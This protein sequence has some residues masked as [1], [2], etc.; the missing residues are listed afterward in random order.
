[1][2]LSTVAASTFGFFNNSTTST[3]QFNLGGT[4]DGQAASGVEVLTFGGTSGG[5]V[6][7]A[8]G[9]GSG[10][11]TVALSKNGRGTWTL[12]GTNTYTGGTSIAGGTLLLD[13]N[14]GGS[15]ATTG[16]LSLGGGVFQIKGASGGSSQTL[17]GTFNV[18]ASSTTSIVLDPNNGTGVTLTLG[19]TWTRG[20]GGS[21]FIDYS[22]ANTGTRMVTT[23]GAVTATGGSTL[24]NGIYTWAVVKDSAGVSG[25]ATQST[26]GGNITRYDDATLATTLT[27]SSAST[28][29]NYSTASST[30]VGGNGGT[31]TWT[32]GGA[33]TNRKINSLIIDTT[34]N[35]GTIDLGASGNVLNMGNN[36]TGGV[37]A[38]FFRGN[39]DE[40]ITG[41][42]IEGGSTASFELQVHQYGT[43]VLTIASAVLGPA[44]NTQFTKDGPGKLVLTGT[45]TFT[46]SSAVASV[47]GGTLKVDG[48]LA[49]SANLVVGGVTSSNN[50]TLAGTGTIGP[51][52]IAGIA[53]GVTS[54]V[55]TINPG[56]VSVIGKINTG[57]LT[58]NGNFTAD[59]DMSTN[60][61][62]GSG[63]GTIVS[64]ANDLINVTGAVTLTNATLSLALTNFTAGATKY[65]Y[66]LI[67]NDS[68]DV[69]TGTFANVLP[70]TGT[71]GQ[72]YTILYT[73]NA[74]TGAAT[75]GNDVAITFTPEPGSF[76]VVSLSAAAA[77]L[78]R[79]R[80]KN[81]NAPSANRT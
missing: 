9:N 73:Y 14:A 78:L 7:G 3:A 20:N 36:A 67:Q 17:G 13:M 54:S 24:T 56:D 74:E 31:L 72:G 59:I 44:A 71:L 43:G 18:A 57:A 50:A 40:I 52:R 29:T 69:I 21:L 51:V 49:N 6:T 48:S 32:N 12:S 81:S 37:G 26:S 34:T 11:G 46:G 4:I 45:S 61:V 42:T 76:G 63:T 47:F 66:V 19:Q 55:G 15:L 10:G 30:Y 64:G 2:L 35:Y 28:T 8:I 58:L 68:N 70:T 22:S 62:T 41:G 53:S 77:S 16:G 39:H 5:T 23:A 60:G 75:G 38:I 65:T 27:T 79:R 33:L 1:M 25:F 80:R